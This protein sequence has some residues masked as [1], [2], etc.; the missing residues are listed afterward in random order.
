M[1]FN[2]LL[3]KGYFRQFGQ[4]LYC[5]YSKGNI[6]N[7]DNY[8]GITLLSAMGKLFTRIFNFR[9]VKIILFI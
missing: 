9:L 2:V 5:T 3:N 4:K 7:V 6:D 1:F 8:R